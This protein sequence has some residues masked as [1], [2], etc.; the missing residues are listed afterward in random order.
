MSAREGLTTVNGISITLGEARSLA[1]RLALDRHEDVGAAA[2]A[3]AR[4][5]ELAEHGGEATLSGEQARAARTAL[6]SWLDETNEDVLGE[7]LLA[8]RERLDT[9]A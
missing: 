6:Q 9:P 5:D 2:E 4:L 3:A 7:R 8:L 1:L